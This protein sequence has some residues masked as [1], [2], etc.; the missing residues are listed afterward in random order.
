MIRNTPPPP[1][2]PP[3]FPR[4][5]KLR[6]QLAYIISFVFNLCFSTDTVTLC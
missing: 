2:P 4:V 5:L 3:T 6:V 1:P